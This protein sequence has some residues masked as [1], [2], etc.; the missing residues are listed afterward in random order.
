RPNESLSFVCSDVP[1]RVEHTDS[2]FLA[3]CEIGQRL[4][5]PVKHGEGCFFA[6]PDLLAELD[7]A[8]QIVLR[9][10][11]ENPNGSI[12]DVAGVTKAAGNVMGLM[13]HPG[14]AVAP[15]PGAP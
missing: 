12:D 8:R 3:G 15:L 9:Y 14:N 6:D 13:P 11:G 4:T 1:V 2:P 7:A 10:D 5:I